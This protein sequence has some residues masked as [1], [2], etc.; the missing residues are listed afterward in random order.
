MPYTYFLDLLSCFWGLASA[1]HFS[2]GV[3]RIKEESISTIA[4][5]FYG[6]GEQ[7][8][9]EL[10]QQRIDFQFGALLLFMTFFSQLIAKLTP[11]LQLIEIDA[12]FW[13]VNAL[14]LMIAVTP[15]VICIPLNIRKRRAAEARIRALN[16]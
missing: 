2:V 1:I 9:V 4:T 15:V 7:M 13:A 3:L 11:Q 5:S 12:G 6:S 8:A 16:A 14:A 10:A